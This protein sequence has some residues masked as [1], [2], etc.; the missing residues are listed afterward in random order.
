MGMK[1]TWSI[2]LCLMLIFVYI[3]TAWAAESSANARLSSTATTVGN[4]SLDQI[5]LSWTDN[6]QTSQTISWRAVSSIKSGKVQYMKES[7]PGDDFS[8]AQ[9][10]KAVCSELYAGFNHFEAEL[11]NLEEGTSYIY[12]VGTE[13]CWSDTSTFTT[14]APTEKFSFMYLGDMH[15]GYDENSAGVCKDL[16]DKA[17]AD[18][19]DLKFALQGG[20]L[21]DQ[22]DDIKQWEEF[23]DMQVGVF[24]HIPFMPAMGNH[25]AKDESIYLK[26]FALPEN[27]PE[28]LKEHDYSFDYGNVHFVVMD[29]NL[30]G[31][32]GDI[33]KAGMEWLENDL[34]DSTKKWKFVMF[35]YPPYGVSSHGNKEC[36]IIKENWVPILERNDVDMVFVGHQHVYMRSYPISEEEVQESPTD[37]ITY[38]LG[39]SGNK[40]YLNPEDSKYISTV[41]AGQDAISYS[42]ISIDDD[43]LTLTTARADGS[44]LDEFKINKSSD[45]DSRLDINSVKLLNSSYDEMSSISASEHFYMQA[46]INNYSSQTQTAL[47]VF[48]VRSG[49][50]AAAEYGGEPLGIASM[51]TGIPVSG[52][53]LYVDFC[54]PGVSPGTAYVDVYIFDEAGV[55]IDLPYEL[56]FNITH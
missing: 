13:G 46:H 6:P 40:T 11:N 25:E 51:Q 30:M 16:I 21:V 55:P 28:G 27:G 5:I 44:I 50:G 20:D 19:P 47:T 39:V 10:T 23:F 29:S 17:L 48:Q 42:L 2:F 36:E 4:S 18:C 43:V 8:A 34:Q 52:A 26:S 32:E 22:T 33:S 31:I 14:A 9:E 38:L 15:V 49:D 24:D 1:K 37:G 3:P 35:H 56:S 53:D 45:M 12:R 7:E 54:L 41:V